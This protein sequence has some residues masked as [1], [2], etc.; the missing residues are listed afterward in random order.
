MKFLGCSSCQLLFSSHLTQTSHT[1]LRHP[2]LCIRFS[3]HFTLS[4]LK[5]R[6]AGDE[7]Q[8]DTYYFSFGF[9]DV[10]KEPGH[11]NWNR[12]FLLFK[13]IQESGLK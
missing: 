12:L 11:G 2:A 4:L 3:R 7:A 1:P 9:V 5:K 6:H 10:G 8:M 13:I